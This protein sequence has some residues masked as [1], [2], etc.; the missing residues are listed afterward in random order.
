MVRLGVNVDHVATLR[1]ARGVDFP[2]PVEAALLAETAGADGI[3]EAV[4]VEALV[5]GH[6]VIK[7]I[8]ALPDGHTLHIEIH[9][10]SYMA[11]D[12]IEQ[13]GITE[14][15]IALVKRALNNFPT[16]RPADIHLIDLRQAV[17]H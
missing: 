2:D 8:V 15:I 6:A 7:Q 1:Q 9:Q 11:F 5:A 10:H 3:T 17:M 12:E 4:M 13:A 16:K 14:G